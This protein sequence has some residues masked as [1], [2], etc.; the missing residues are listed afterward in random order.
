MLQETYSTTFKKVEQLVGNF[1]SKSCLNQMDLNTSKN[2]LIIK[3]W[4]IFDITKVW[5]H[6]DYP[7]VPVGRF[8]LNRNH[9]NY[10]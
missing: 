2:I 9:E 8:V 10:F 1:I 5:P 6:S 3:R 7:L 4:N